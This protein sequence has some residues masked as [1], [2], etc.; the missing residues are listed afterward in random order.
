[1][2]H[3]MELK[4]KKQHLVFSIVFVMFFLVL[5]GCIPPFSISPIF[6]DKDIVYDPDL[7]GNWAAKGSDDTWIFKNA[8]EKYDFYHLTIVTRDGVSP[9][10]AY[11]VKIKDTLYLDVSTD[12]RFFEGGRDLTLAIPVHAFLRVRKNG[13]EWEMA[14]INEKWFDKYIKDNPDAIPHQ[15]IN[16]EE[17]E[18]DQDYLLTGSTEE[19]QS[20]LIKIQGI[21]DAWEPKP[22]ILQRLKP[23]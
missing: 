3:V 16:P 4:M 14:L 8:K 12:S 17:E 7:A 18:K 1:M 22:T 6:N 13:A 9:F 5:S 19:M 23:E 10:N 2:S 20:F 21:N 15:V 11:L